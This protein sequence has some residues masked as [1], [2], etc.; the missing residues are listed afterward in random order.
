[1]LVHLVWE[2]FLL[3]VLIG[4]VGAGLVLFPEFR[5][6]DSAQRVV[7]L[8]ALIGIPA[9]AFSFS[10]RGAVPNLAVVPLAALGGSV[11]AA[12]SPDQGLAAGLLQA[13]ALPGIVGLVIGALVVG[14]RVPSWAA[15]IAAGLLATGLS[16][17]IAVGPVGPVPGLPPTVPAEVLLFA[18]FAVLSVGT[19]L[20]CLVPAFRRTLGA[21]RQDAE[22]GTRGLVAGFVALGVLVVSSAV[23]G[24]G[25]IASV[26]QTE[27]AG[28]AGGAGDLLFPLAAVLVG[29][30]S[31]YGR[32]VGVAGT[33]LGVLVV[34]TI[35]DLW[36][37]SGLGEGYAGYGGV[38][39]LA[40]IAAIVG[41]LATPLVEWSGR[42]A[43]TR[44]TT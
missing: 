34:V 38:L 19:G 20:L 23:A 6:V 29:G 30:A 13:L 37:L 3:V 33:V 11:Y 18:V 31:V 24:A 36:L 10:L 28:G 21:Y 27:I 7:G 40:G 16:L 12:T 26:A 2:G 15:S 4:L 14:L 17:A 32:R 22:E 43:E 41:L 5:S 39:A 1:V 42:R 8:S 44:V 35:R 9:M 25:G